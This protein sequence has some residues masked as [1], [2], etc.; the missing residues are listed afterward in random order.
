MKA[1]LCLI[2]IAASKRYAECIIEKRKRDEKQ[3]A[4]VDST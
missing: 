3:P 2:G 4:H 1:Y